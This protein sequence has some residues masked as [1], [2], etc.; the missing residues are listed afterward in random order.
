MIMALLLSDDLE[1]ATSDEE[2]SVVGRVL[3]R[4]NDFRKLA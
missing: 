1:R 2:M 4:D 3:V